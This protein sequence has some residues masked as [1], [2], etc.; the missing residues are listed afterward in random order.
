[1]LWLFLIN[2][3]RIAMRCVYDSESL[4]RFHSRTAPSITVLEYLRRIVKY[5]NVEVRLSTISLVG[6]TLTLI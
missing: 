6:L 4:T 5:A 2:G 1:M 3:I